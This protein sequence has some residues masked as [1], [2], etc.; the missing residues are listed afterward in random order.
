VDFVLTNVAQHAHG[1][2]AYVAIFGVLVACGLGLPLPEDVSLITG[3]FLTHQGQAYLPLMMGVGFLGIIAGDSII[4]TAG[5]RLGA[6]VGTKQ[7]GFFAR[8]VTPA[9]RARV[10]GLFHAH[11]Q[12]IV[13]AARFLPGVRAVTFFT[14]GS[15]GMKYRW[16]ILW[17]GLA[18][19]VSAPLLVFLGFYF[20]DELALVIKKVRQGQIRVI[21]VIVL[22]AA[23]YIAYSRWRNR[24]NKAQTAADASEPPTGANGSDGSPPSAN[25]RGGEWTAPS[26]DL[27]PQAS[28]SAP[29]GKDADVPTL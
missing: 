15:A 4:F 17:D 18:A 24:R 16:F 29:E 10:E 20:G 13:M 3:G 28:A 7:T 14:A 9:K 25:G 19:L 5:R 23:A 12:K 21:A 26:Q 1:I 8:I 22:L 27:R 6:K 2:L 11:G